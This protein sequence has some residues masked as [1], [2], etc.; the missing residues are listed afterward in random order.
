MNYSV[1]SHWLPLAASLTEINHGKSVVTM[2]FCCI[3]YH[4]H[5]F[6]TNTWL[7]YGQCS[8]MVNLWL[9]WFNY[10]N[11]G[12]INGKTMVNVRDDFLIRNMNI[13]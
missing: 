7:S 3:D 1:V 2:F 8:K 4:N 10:S 6:T 9:L 12:F 5:S 11:H 13:G